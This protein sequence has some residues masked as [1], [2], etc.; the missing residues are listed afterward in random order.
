MRFMWLPASAASCLPTGT[1][2][3]NETLRTMGEAMRYSDTSCGTPHTTLSTPGGRPASWN[4]RAIATTALGESSGPLRMMVQPAA[5]AA[6]ILRMA[7]LYGK[8]QGVKAAH[9]PMGSRST[10]CRTLGRRGGTTR[11]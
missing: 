7:W 9:T 5:M 4:S 10:S 6:A 1:E 8:F 2:P 3:V 11:P